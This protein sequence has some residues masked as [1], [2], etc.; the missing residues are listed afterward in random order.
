M[1]YVLDSFA[2]DV[3]ERRCHA[4]SPE[5]GD[6]PAE[7]IDERLHLRRGA[8]A[9]G[10]SRKVGEQKTSHAFPFVLRRAG[11]GAGKGGAGCCADRG[12]VP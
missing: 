11:A 10:V 8:G 9:R 6:E 7:F 2:V 12:S 1:A 3:R 5:P 4:T